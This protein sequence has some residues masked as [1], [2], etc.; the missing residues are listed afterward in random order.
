MPKQTIKYAFFSL[1]FLFFFQ[2]LPAQ[3]AVDTTN[4]IE[5]F[6]LTTSEMPEINLNTAPRWWEKF[7]TLN[8][9][10]LDRLQKMKER[11]EETTA[12]LK[13]LKKL[14]L[15]KESK[16]AFFGMKT[17]KA[18]VRSKRGR[19][20]TTE[21]FRYIKYD[22][23]PPALIEEKMF[24]DLKKKKIAVS[25]KNFL[26]NSKLLHGNFVRTVN[27]F[28]VEQGQYYLGVKHGVWERF[29]ATDSAL[30]DKRTYYQGFLEDSEITYFDSKQTRFKEIIPVHNEIKDGQYFRFFPSGRLAETGMY[31][32]NA[33][34]GVW[35]EYRDTELYRRYRET[36]YAKDPFDENHQPYIIREWDEKG[37][38]TTNS[39]GKK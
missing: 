33:R 9:R 29:N 22:R 24:F 11:A 34:V 20:I 14:A 1:I 8:K 37:K 26:K 25:E 7:V 10:E 30:L 28:V 31:R 2:N 5:G 6:E 21:K 15:K 35:E 32:E 17:K 16:S 3:N 27:G 38:L 12:E 39:K 36:Q 19:R 23:K 13:K 18:V 4:H